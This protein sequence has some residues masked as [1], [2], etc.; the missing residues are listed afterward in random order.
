MRITLLLA[1]AAVLAATACGVTT[2]SNPID[3]LRDSRSKYGP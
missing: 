2:I 3:A 1:F